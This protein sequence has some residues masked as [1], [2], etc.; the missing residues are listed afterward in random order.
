MK[1]I[2]PLYK[3]KTHIPHS[4]SRLILSLTIVNIFF[5]DHLNNPAAL[6]SATLPKQSLSN[7]GP[8][9]PMQPP[10]G[11][12]KTS[13]PY[14]N[15]SVPPGETGGSAGSPATTT[16]TPGLPGSRPP[17]RQ[18]SASA[19]P[20]GQDIQAAHGTPN[21]SLSAHPASSE[22]GQA[23]PPRGPP[24]R[25]MT[26]EEMMVLRRQQGEDVA[27]KQAPNKDCFIIPQGNLE[28]FLPDG[29]TVRI[30]VK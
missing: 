14:M 22:P 24:R 3:N 5:R 20:T 9:R 29:I 15:G 12:G 28:R 2:F 21:G 18:N 10:P 11:S 8:G 16:G 6:G 4:F 27:A 23:G 7:G 19:T 25:K 30:E 26:R 17:R 1:V 13:D